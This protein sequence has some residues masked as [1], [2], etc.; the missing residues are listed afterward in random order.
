MSEKQPHGVIENFRIST[1]ASNLE[2]LSAEV[3]AM[4]VAIGL[5]FQKMAN[6]HRDA[7]LVE[8]RQLGNPWMNG[9]A[10]QLEQF[11]I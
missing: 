8:L 6:H 4:K 5:I 1:D 9:L 10:D 7:F 2:N 3:T 11:K